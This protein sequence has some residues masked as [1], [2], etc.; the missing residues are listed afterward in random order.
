MSSTFKVDPIEATAARMNANDGVGDGWL[1]GRNAVDLLKSRLVG[2]DVMRR[3]R[4]TL[5]FS[6]KK[7]YGDRI[8]VDMERRFIDRHE[9]AEKLERAISQ[10]AAGTFGQDNQN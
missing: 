10:E 6:L 5:Y 4:S 1:Y 7:V 3:Y 2:A 8:A 9:A